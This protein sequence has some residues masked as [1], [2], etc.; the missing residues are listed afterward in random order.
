MDTCV[1]VVYRTA[2]KWPS[3]IFV[4]DEE[5]VIA[6]LREQAQKPTD[7]RGVIEIPFSEYSEAN[8]AEVRA[9]LAKAIGEPAPAVRIVAV[10]AE[11][12]VVHVTEHPEPERFIAQRSAADGVQ[13]EVHDKAKHGAMK[14]SEGVFLNPPEEIAAVAPGKPNPDG[15]GGAAKLEFPDGDV[16]VA[17][18]GETVVVAKDGREIS[19]KQG[20]SKNGGSILI[21]P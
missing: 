3:R 16:I 1:F 19:R 20:D 14:L 21:Q 17:G 15:L 6:A 12:T 8:D 4:T 7:D 18:P 11:G 13:Y 2:S 9:F 10:D 5:K